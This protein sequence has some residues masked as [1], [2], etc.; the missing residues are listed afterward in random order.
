MQAFGHFCLITNLKKNEIVTV[1]RIPGGLSVVHC[2]RKAINVICEDSQ[3][4]GGGRS[5]LT[6]P[7]GS[8]LSK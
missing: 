2:S 6:W 5:P 1:T 3:T 8:L 4:A 7:R